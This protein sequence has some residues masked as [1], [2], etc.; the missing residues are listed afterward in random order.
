MLFDVFENGMFWG[1]FLKNRFK[2]K[3]PHTTSY[4]FFIFSCMKTYN[5]IWKNDNRRH[6]LEHAHKNGMYSFTCSLNNR[7]WEVVNWIEG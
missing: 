3:M 1:N 7:A 4:Y 2:N 6:F 5:M